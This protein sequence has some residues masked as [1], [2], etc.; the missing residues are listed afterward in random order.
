MRNWRISHDKC[1]VIFAWFESRNGL[2]I[3]SEWM[4]GG[5]VFFSHFDKVA[6]PEKYDLTVE[7]LRGVLRVAP[8]W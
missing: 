8:T 5:L 4:S 1:G 2:H 7:L 3:M 6:R